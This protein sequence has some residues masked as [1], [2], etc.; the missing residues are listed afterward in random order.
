MGNIVIHSRKEQRYRCKRCGKTFSATTDTPF[1]RVHKSHALLV[2]VVTLLAHGCPTQAIVAAFGLDERTVADWQQRAG[3]QC[4][5]MHRYLVQAEQVELGQMQ[6]DEVRVRTVGAAGVRGAGLS[7][8]PPC[9][10]GE[11]LGQDPCRYGHRP[12]I[13]L[14]EAVP[15]RSWPI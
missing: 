12:T 3:D 5:R 6:A 11:E 13:M 9:I 4:A 8:E 2:T 1:Y 14:S 7:L 15:V 10:G